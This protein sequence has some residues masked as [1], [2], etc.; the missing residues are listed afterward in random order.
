MTILTLILALL[1]LAPMVL[2]MIRDGRIKDATTAE[3]INAFENEFNKRWQA[4]VDAA[5]AAGNSAGAGAANNV[6][7]QSN[8]SV[9]NPIVTP[10][11]NDPFDRA[12]ARRKG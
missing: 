3:V 10:E 7:V 1:R 5:V 6:G 11:G 8:T 12:S 9:S 4:R 2:E